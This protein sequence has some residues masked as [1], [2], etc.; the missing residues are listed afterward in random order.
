MENISWGPDN[1]LS[2][3]PA[4][5]A[6]VVQLSLLGSILSNLLLVLGRARRGRRGH[7]AAPSSVPVVILHTNENGVRRNDPS[8]LV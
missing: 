3:G 1:S 4:S 5:R 7:S 8:A 2:R 6:Q